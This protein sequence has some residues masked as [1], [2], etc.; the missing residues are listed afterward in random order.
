LQWSSNADLDLHVTEPN[1]TEISYLDR[2]PTSTGGQ[3][4][5]DSNVGCNLNGAIEN[6]FWP[7]DQ[8]APAGAYSIAVTGYRVGEDN[9]GSGDYTLT[10]RVEGQPERSET[11]SVTSGESDPYTFNVG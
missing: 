5:K 9:C 1:G 10:I 7:G 4:D 8:P 2:G 6:V 11:G 3:L